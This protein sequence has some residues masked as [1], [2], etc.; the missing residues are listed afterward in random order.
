MSLEYINRRGQSHWFRAVPTAKGGTRYYVVKSAEYPDLLEDLPPGFEIAEQPWDARVVLRK[1]VPVLTTESEREMFEEH[2]GR[3]SGL[4]DFFVHAEGNY[5]TLWHSQYN[6]IG[7]QE[8]N[9]SA[10]GAAEVFGP[11]VNRWKD[12][13]D[14]FRLRLIDPA[15]RIFQS[16]RRVYTDFDAEYGA[17]QHAVGELEEMLE[18][19]CSFLGRDDFFDL[20]PEG[21][22]E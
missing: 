10:E 8:D 21:W 4:N 6:S 15:A 17:I 2:V 1:A 13:D 3:L 20:V 14:A 18:A 5:L 19:I 11:E 22:E 9:L 7:G 16:E 12:Y